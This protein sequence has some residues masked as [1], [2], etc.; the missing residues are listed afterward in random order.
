[1]SLVDDIADR[2]TTQSVA[3]T[4]TNLFKDQMPST[5]D[6]LIALYETG[7]P[8]PVRVMGVS[9][10]TRP[11]AEQPHLQ[12]IV[13]A[14]RSDAARKLAR[15]VFHN[16]EAV[17]PVTINNVVYY[18]ILA[19]QTPFFLRKDESGRYEFAVNFEITRQFVTS[20]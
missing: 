13:R 10:G 14:T 2:L 15:D 8:A 7:G 16:L 20:S 12:V 17:G 6:E 1:M 9:T 3:T 19:L 11:T 4:G 5:P 18:G